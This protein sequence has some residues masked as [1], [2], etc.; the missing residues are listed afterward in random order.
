MDVPI[1]SSKGEPW[2][3]EVS[4]RGRITSMECFCAA[5]VRGLWCK[6]KAALIEGDRSFCVEGHEAPF[7]EAHEL[8]QGTD[9]PALWAEMKEEWADIDIKMGVL[10][11]RLKKLKYSLTRKLAKGV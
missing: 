9:I 11:E 5:S 2:Y 10:K 6:H 7:D 8:I 4:T 1:K 3:I